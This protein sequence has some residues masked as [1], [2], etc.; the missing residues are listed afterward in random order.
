MVSCTDGSEETSQVS[1]LSGDL[2]CPGSFPVGTCSIL[3]F[4][5][6]NFMTVVEKVLGLGGD[7]GG[8]G[9]DEA[10][11]TGRKDRCVAAQ[12]SVQSRIGR[13]G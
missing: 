13:R 1:R 11:E 10:D 9:E 3:V 4:M 12:D 8:G 5:V 7:G 6:A 2:K